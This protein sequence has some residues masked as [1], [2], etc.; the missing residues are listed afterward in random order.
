MLVDENG[1]LC[2]RLNTFY[3]T[4]G[5]TASNFGVAPERAM[6][7]L[8]MFPNKVLR[9]IVDMSSFIAHSDLRFFPVVLLNL[10]FLQESR[11]PAAACQTYLL[12]TAYTVYVNDHFPWGQHEVT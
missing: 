1:F 5:P 7:M 6:L 3:K 8:E 12:V 2:V 4:Y 11:Y 9:N 10:V